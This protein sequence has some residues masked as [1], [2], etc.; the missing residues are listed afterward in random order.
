MDEAILYVL[1]APLPGTR[2]PAYL[3]YE[4]GGVNCVL[5]YT[6]RERL[7][8]CCGDYQPW[9]AVQSRALMADLR[10]RGLSG[11]AINMPLGAAVRWTAE[12]PPWGSGPA[13][14]EPAERASTEPDESAGIAP[15]E[16][17]GPG[18]DDTVVVPTAPLG[19]GAAG[20]A[21]G[22]DRDTVP[23]TRE[24]PVVAGNAVLAA[25]K[26]KEWWR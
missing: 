10:D 9:V 2:T 19:A 5:A 14:G 15:E 12:G 20:E 24:V 21:P 1:A 18:H 23:L 22:T 17:R 26:V 13:D 11:P 16:R 7:V 3:M 8:E 25:P 6:D 4:V